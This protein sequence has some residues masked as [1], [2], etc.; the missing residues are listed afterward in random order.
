MDEMTAVQQEATTPT[1]EPEIDSIATENE[2]PS[3]TPQAEEK[4]NEEANSNTEQNIPEAEGFKLRYNHEDVDVTKEE[5][6]RLAQIGKHYENISKEFKNEDIKSI[7]SDLDYFAALQNKSVKD[8]VSDMLN[9]VENSY[10]QELTEE[11]GE[12][13]PL[14]E[15]M[16]E[17]R[18]S[19]NMKAYEDAKSQKSIKAE[20][21][22]AEAEKT[23]TQNLAT[24]FED[25]CKEF[26]EYNTVA[27]VPDVVYKEALKSGD[28]EK[29]ILRFK[30]AE[31]KVI[32]ETEKNEIKN[33]NENIGS[34]NTGGDAQSSLVS[35]M[36]KGIWG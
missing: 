20:Q 32:R 34:V 36:L 16:L 3:A 1:A 35:E 2:E 22:A 8:V 14:I 31:E 11:L 26:P 23:L 18:K 10:R 5:A 9:G 12:G 33:K 29:E 30:L 28:L 25:I 27:D 17:L 4:P 21:E 13:N 15:E 7:L 19:K 24:Q 6:I